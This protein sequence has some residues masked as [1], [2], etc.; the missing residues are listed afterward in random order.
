[1]FKTLGY[2]IAPADIGQLIQL[3]DTDGNGTLDFDE[4]VALMDL[5]LKHEEETTG[6]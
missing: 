6:S 4:F 3:V 1:M 5:F 2:D